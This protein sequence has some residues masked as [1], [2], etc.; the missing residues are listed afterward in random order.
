MGRIPGLDRR[1][2]RLAWL[3]AGA[4][5]PAMG[6]QEIGGRGQCAR[7]AFKIADAIF[8]HRL[9][10]KLRLADLAMHRAALTSAQRATVDQFQR[11]IKLVC[12]IIRPPAIVSERCD[13]GE[14]VLIAA[15]AAEGALHAPDRNQWPRRHAIA[16]LDRS[17]QRG[18]PLL[19]AAAARHDRSR[20][21]LDHELIEREL[22]TMQAA[23][24]VDS[25]LRV[26]RRQQGRDTGRADA[27][28]PR[29]LGERILP[30]L[31]SGGAVAALR[32][33]GVGARI[34]EYC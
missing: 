21:A 10:Q 8:Q 30:G 6:F 29:L 14:H 11:S 27:L 7:R 17:E 22:E 15:L 18:V 19:H 2:I 9:G 32:G 31:E 1:E 23:I 28:R 3:I 25:R 4:S 16:L 34:G 24:G 12:E 5:L 26:V 33:V 20:A 13:G